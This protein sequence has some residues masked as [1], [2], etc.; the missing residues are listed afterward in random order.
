MQDDFIGEVPS[1]RRMLSSHLGTGQGF[2]C[3]WCPLLKRRELDFSFFLMH[4]QAL[5]ENY[6][7]REEKGDYR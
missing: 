2:H 5:R 6:F 3:G 7:S 1:G 4:F